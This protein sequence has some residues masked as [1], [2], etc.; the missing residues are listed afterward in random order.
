MSRARYIIASISII[1]L[2][3]AAIAYSQAY[4]PNS[5][6]LGQKQL[7]SS[8]SF[9]PRP[10]GL[11]PSGVNV[12]VIG[13]LKGSSVT[14]ACSLSNPPCAAVDTSI[15]YV[16]VSG[17]NYR[18]IFPN[19]TQSPDV[20][21]HRVLVTGLYITPSSYDSTQWTPSIYF[22][23]DIYVQTITYLHYLT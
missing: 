21:G 19:S 3:M 20:F 15:Y 4:Q 11:N 17:W 6:G 7:S 23:G 18:L 8:P 10:P 16:V 13:V 1:A 2:A 14:P 12:S 9:D 5:F 22:R